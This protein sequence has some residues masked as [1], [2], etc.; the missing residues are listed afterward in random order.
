MAP[1]RG[2][3]VAGELPHLGTFVRAAELGGFT[4]AA[5]D[6]GVTQAAVSQ[7]VAA[8]EK[9]LR[10]PLFDRRAGGIR[11]TEG[12]E[13]LYGFAR[14]ILA[15]HEEARVGLGA[16]PRPV[17][18]D[19]P[20]ST[21]SVPGECLLPA[22]LAAFR[23]AYPR[24]QVRAT[25]GDSRSAIA[26]VERGAA[27]L[28]LVGRKDEGGGLEY[29]PI[30]TD[31][32]V[33]VVPPAH[34][35]ARRG[36]ISLRRLGREPLI[37]R[38]PGSGTRSV[39]E[40]GLALAGTSIAA[41]TVT[42]ELGSNAAII[43]GVRRGLGVAFLSRAAVQRELDSGGLRGVEVRGLDLGRQLYLVFDRRRPLTPAARAFRQFLESRTPGGG[44]AGCP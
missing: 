29:R 22:L 13:R 37:L 32:L 27:V 42:L 24:V 4:A 10:I 7:R 44:A 16:A 41:L 20:L 39:L 17:A 23:E 38:E 30:G 19:L 25:V 43:D 1:P 33:L 6:L 40:Q 5:A 8:L 21:S 12:G 14:R 34:P 9:V 36:A 2:T 28:G 26:D 15:L 18:G 31:C 35:W 11:L 3:P